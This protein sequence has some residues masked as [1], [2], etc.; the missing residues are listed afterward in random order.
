ML[1]GGVTRSDLWIHDVQQ[2]TAKPLL[3][4][5][6]QRRMGAPVAGRPMDASR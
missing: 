4:S 5:E 2:N 6:F 3:A 1:N